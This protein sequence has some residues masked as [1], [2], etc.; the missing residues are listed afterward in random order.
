MN[1]FSPFCVAL[2]ATLFLPVIAFSMEANIQKDDRK[3]GDRSVLAI[4][5]GVEYAFR[6]C[7]PGTFTMGSEG[8]G[9]RGPQRQITL[10]RGFWMLET[11]VTQAMWTSVMGNNP[12]HFK[13]DKRPVEMVSWNDAQEYI[14]KLNDLEVAPAGFKFSLPTEAQWEYA[15]RAG[16]TTAFHFGDTL[17]KEQ[18]NIGNFAGYDLS[19]RPI[20][21]RTEGQTFSGVPL[22]RTEGET[23]EVGSY[24]ANAWGLHDMHG[25]VQE[26]VW[27]W[28]GGYPWNDVSDPIGAVPGTRRMHRGGHWRS[29]VVNSDAAHRTSSSPSRRADII[30]FRLALVRAES[31]PVEATPSR[32]IIIPP[33]N[34]APIHTIIIPFGYDAMTKDKQKDAAIIGHAPMIRLWIGSSYK[35]PEPVLLFA[36]W[37]NGTIIWAKSG[38]EKMSLDEKN[39]EHFQSKISEKQVEDFLSAFDKIDFLEFS[40]KMAPRARVDGPGLHF[41]L[42]ETVDVQ[43]SFCMDFLFWYDSPLVPRREEGRRMADK[44][45]ATKGLLLELIPEKGEQISLSIEEEKDKR[46]WVITPVATRRARIFFRSN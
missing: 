7:P 14:Q 41:F 44:W 3:A 4:K 36:L 37:R 23:K 9:N 5:K 32:K 18:A 43:F 45:Q 21:V 16:T 24:P 33:E 6:W 20:V 46:Q 38:D 19:A 8:G 17:T 29:N 34:V 28:L 1:Q 10:T 27:D 42:L 39:Q 22:R 11:E 40:G 15:C 30:G 26:W 35:N 13:G 31:L 2:V 12:S 25:N